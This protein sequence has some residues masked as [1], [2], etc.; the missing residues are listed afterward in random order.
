M[1]NTRRNLI[2]CTLPCFIA[3]LFRPTCSQTATI[4]QG[5]QLK[6]DQQL[7]STSGMFKLGFKSL[8]KD[9][10]YLGIWYYGED[11]NLLWV[12]NRNTP[13][14]RSSGVLEIDDR[15]SLKILHPSADPVVLYTVEEPYKRAGRFD[16]V[17]SSPSYPIPHTISFTLQTR[18][19]R[20]SI[21]P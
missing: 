4:T 10:S 17:F 15:G 8:H 13:I 12:A 18:M 14:F 5:Q 2:L 20:T 19:K 11:D 1:A 21:I 16:M 3:L 7:V 6:H 9:N